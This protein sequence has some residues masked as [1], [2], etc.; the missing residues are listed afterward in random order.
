MNV[1]TLNPCPLFVEKNV[2]QS[3]N[4]CKQFA[5]GSVYQG[6]SVALTRQFENIR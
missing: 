2:V 6:M 1:M 4:I 3:E 5:D